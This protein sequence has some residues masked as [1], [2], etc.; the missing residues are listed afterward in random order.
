MKTE[1]WKRETVETGE[2]KGDALTQRRRNPNNHPR[3]TQFRIEIRL[4]HDIIRHF[5][6][7]DLRY[8]WDYSDG[9]FYI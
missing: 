2:T 5:G 9:Q 4:D 3:R 6:R 7:P 1:R 8:R